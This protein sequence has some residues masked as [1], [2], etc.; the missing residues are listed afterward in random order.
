M[1]EGKNF[2]KLIGLT[3]ELISLLIL[4]VLVSHYLLSDILIKFGLN[5]MIGTFA[6]ILFLWGIL[7]KKIK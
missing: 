1:K 6:I 2:I 3:I 5:A 7:I 4:I